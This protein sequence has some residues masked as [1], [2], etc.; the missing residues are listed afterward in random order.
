MAVNVPTHRAPHRARGRGRSLAILGALAAVLASGCGGTAA[1]RPSSTGRPSASPSPAS[2]TATPRTSDLLAGV[3]AG[4]ADVQ[5]AAAAGNA[6]A[7]ELLQQLAS[8]Q[9]D[10]NFVDS[11]YSLATVLAMV[12]LGAEGNTQTQIGAVLQSAGVSPELQAAAWKQLDAS[13]LTTAQADGIS[14][15]DANAIW[16]EQGLPFNAT[17]LNTL[18]QNFS[19]PSSQVDF[20][21]DPQGAADLINQWVSDATHG[22]IPA[23]VS[24]DDVQP[25]K[26]VLADA[27][28]FDADWQYRFLAENTVSGPFHRADG[29]QVS[30]SMMKGGLWTLSAYVGDGV[31]AVEMPYVGGHFAADVIMP[32]SQSLGSFIAG[33][34]PASLNA[35]GQDLTSTDDVY[36]TLPK[37]DISSKESLIPVLQALGM[38]DAFDGAAADF[39]GIDGGRDLYVGLLEQRADINVDEIGTTAAAATILGGLGAGGPLPP[40]TYITID[41]PFLFVIR[42]TVTGAIVF[43]AQ[44]VDPTATT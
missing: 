26:L 37:F 43:T 11:A 19:A 27:I 5:A 13:L 40:I 24:A 42:D 10:A 4:A 6:L 31:T 18:V 7:V 14:L 33:M 2:A 28:Y 34:T 38:T 30:A 16:L 23:V 44:V 39:S 32:T 8:S 17:F 41:H 3:T 20:S 1:I 29:S 25:L 21:G 22:M 12:E 9:P 15:D 36:L 35:I